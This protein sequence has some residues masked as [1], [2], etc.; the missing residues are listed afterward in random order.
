MYFGVACAIVKSACNL[1]S[2][3]LPLFLCCALNRNSETP[4]FP[5][6]VT[7]SPH[8]RDAASTF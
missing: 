1:L 4:D 8:Y 3:S 6:N 7:F 2:P 5:H